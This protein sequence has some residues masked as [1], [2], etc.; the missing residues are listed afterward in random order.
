MGSEGRALWQESAIQADD[1]FG[2]RYRCDGLGQAGGI[3]S[4]WRAAI[5]SYLELLI[6][7]GGRKQTK[8]V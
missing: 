6:D 7:L 2:S 5:K 3:W 4:P 8:K 1:L